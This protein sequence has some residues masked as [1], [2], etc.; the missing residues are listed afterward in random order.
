MKCR[1]EEQHE[2]FPALWPTCPPERDVELNSSAI[3]AGLARRLPRRG[4]GSLSA[5]AVPP[6]YLYDDPRLHARVK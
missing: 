4:N 3:L 2:N 5:E 6:F 1:C